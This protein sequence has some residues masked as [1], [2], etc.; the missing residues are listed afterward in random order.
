MVGSHSVRRALCADGEVATLNLACC[1]IGIQGS[2]RP[3]FS[4]L[5]KLEKYNCDIVSILIVRT[6]N[7]LHSN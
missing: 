6:Y 5:N 2:G 4:K 3:L 1:T 7:I